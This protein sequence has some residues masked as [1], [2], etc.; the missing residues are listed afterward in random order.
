MQCFSTGFGQRIVCLKIFL[1]VITKCSKCS[2]FLH[3]SE[4]FCR[5]SDTPKNGS[6]KSFDQR[7]FFVSFSTEDVEQEI[8]KIEIKNTDVPELTHVLL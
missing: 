3:K 2:K 5:T 7:S 6:I 1:A 4:M 8:Y